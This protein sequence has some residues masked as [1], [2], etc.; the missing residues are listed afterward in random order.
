M[1]LLVLRVPVCEKV[2]EKD[3]K[4]PLPMNIFLLPNEL[5][6]HI[7]SYTDGIAARVCLLWYSLSPDKRVHLSSIN[8]PG[9]LEWALQQGCQS[10]KYRHT[11]VFTETGVDNILKEMYN[12]VK[13]DQSTEEYSRTRCV[14]IPMWT[15]DKK[16]MFVSAIGEMV[17]KQSHWKVFLT[18]SCAFYGYKSL[19]SQDDLYTMDHFGKREVNRLG[20]LSAPTWHGHSDTLRYLESLVCQ[21][22][23]V[24][25]SIKGQWCLQRTV[26]DRNHCQMCMKKATVKK[27]Y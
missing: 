14:K 7:L 1:Y 19:L 13:Y 18:Y 4:N 15:C 5:L 24:S 11:G 12:M 25:G 2:E 20:L 8:T 6:Q 27:L 23:Y 26:K 9:L 21:W 10:W 3:E 17:K 22:I 16:E